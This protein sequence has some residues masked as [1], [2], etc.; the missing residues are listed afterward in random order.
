MGKTYRK[1]PDWMKDWAERLGDTRH[2][3]MLLKG[4]K[5]YNTNKIGSATVDSAGTALFNKWDDVG[6]KTP[7]AS[8]QRRR[9]AK[10]QILVEMYE[11]ALENSPEVINWSAE[12]LADDILDCTGLEVDI[13]LLREVVSNYSGVIR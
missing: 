6:S 5:T 2:A 12:E 7:H 1:V 10:K 4:V 9:A 11:N 13:E 3:K 8:R